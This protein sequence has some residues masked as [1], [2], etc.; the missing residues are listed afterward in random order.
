MASIIN[1]FVSKLLSIVFDCTINMFTTEKLIMVI[2]TSD[3]ASSILINSNASSKA[4][5]YVIPTDR[6]KNKKLN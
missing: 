3:Q 5:E 4:L 2:Q 6:K 1:V